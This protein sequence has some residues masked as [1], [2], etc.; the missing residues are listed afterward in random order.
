MPWDYGRIVR[1]Y[2]KRHT[3]LLDIDTGGGEILLSFRHPYEY[4]SATEGYP[5][6]VD[7]CKQVLLPLGIDFRE[8]GD[9]K[10][11]PLIWSLTGM[12]T[13]M[14]GNYTVY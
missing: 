11:V 1:G 2:L 7:L 8:A 5:P 6:N 4:T 3:R 13:L 10:T 12:G 9:V 14:P